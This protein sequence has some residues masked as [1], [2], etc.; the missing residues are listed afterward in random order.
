[1]YT[2]LSDCHKRGGFYPPCS[3]LCCPDGWRRWRDTHAHPGPPCISSVLRAPLPN[4]T[5]RTSPTEQRYSQ[6][7]LMQR[8]GTPDVTRRFTSPK[9]KP[10]PWGCPPIGLG[11]SCP[12]RPERLLPADGDVTQQHWTGTQWE[13]ELSVSCLGSV[14]AICR[15]AQIMPLSAATSTALMRFFTNEQ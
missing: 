10:G 1:M 11:A 2:Q 8:K 15:A 12:S 14:A 4:T 3:Q 6:P 7:E 9:K 13:N 5:H